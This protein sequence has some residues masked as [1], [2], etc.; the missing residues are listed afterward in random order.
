[1]LH[2]IGFE[3][4][5]LCQNPNLRP[6]EP[7]DPPRKNYGFK[8]REFTRDNVRAPADAPMPTAK[9]LAIMAGPPAAA[10]KGPTGPKAT[11]PN[12]VYAVLEENRANERQ[13]GK[14]E[15]VIKKIKSKRRRDYLLLLVLGNLSI[16]T[17]VA[18]GGFNPVS[19]IFGLSGIIVLSLGA[20]WIMW[21][22][23]DRY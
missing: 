21:F 8:E 16:V 22:V 17:M 19:M 1:M 23:M 15:I 18:L 5:I 10:A 6:M 4:A 3:A 13:L 14:D 2:V 11:D 12:D 7:D 20:T 9:E